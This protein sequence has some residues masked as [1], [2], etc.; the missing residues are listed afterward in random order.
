MLEARN[1]S[2]SLNEILSCPRSMLAIKKKASP[3]TDA[4]ILITSK[5]PSENEKSHPTGIFAIVLEKGMK[6]ISD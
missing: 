4:V 1:S 6:K 5:G 2:A 3:M